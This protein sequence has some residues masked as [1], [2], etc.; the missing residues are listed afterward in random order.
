MKKERP[1]IGKRERGGSYG[2]V[3]RYQ[4]E[5]RN[6]VIIISQ[7]SILKNKQEKNAVLPN[8]KPEFIVSSLHFPKRKQH[9]TDKT[10]LRSALITCLHDSL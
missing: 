6:A 2:R 3:Y 10:L 9:K 8:D 7:K 4:N 5:G 1:Q